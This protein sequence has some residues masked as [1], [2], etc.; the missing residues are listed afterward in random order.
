V[1]NDT[2]KSALA[3]VVIISGVLCGCAGVDVPGSATGGASPANSVWVTVRWE[4]T[5]GNKE[6]A[7]SS[8]VYL[9]RDKVFLVDGIFQDASET[10]SETISDLKAIGFEVGSGVQE[11]C[12]HK[13]WQTPS[14]A[15]FVGDYNL[16]VKFLGMRDNAYYF[17]STVRSSGPFSKERELMIQHTFGVTFGIPCRVR[18][19]SAQIAYPNYPGIISTMTKVRE[20]SCLNL[21]GR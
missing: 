19:L 5:M 4:D 1:F 11:K 13:K 18:L 15:G 16:C 17:D 7:A 20:Q 14:P 21:R 6:A 12:A 10:R 9:D 3:P 8:T 2:I